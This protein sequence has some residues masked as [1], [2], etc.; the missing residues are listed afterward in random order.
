MTITK[1]WQDALAYIQGKVPK[2]VYDT[3]FTPIHL[4]RIEDSTAQLGV[5]NKFFG[6]WLSQHY[7]TLLTEAVSAARGGEET[8]ITFVIFH[9]QATRQTENSGSNAATSRQNTVVAGETGNTAQ[10]KVYIQE[11]RSGG[12]KPIF[13]CRLYGGRRTAGEGL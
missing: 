12:G 13:P 7:G 1:E 11:F 3:W 6:D 2:Q 8:A 10:P 5:P 4:E 9:K